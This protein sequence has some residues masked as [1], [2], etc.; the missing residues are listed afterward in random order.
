MFEVGVSSVRIGGA[1]SSDIV[2][3]AGAAEI[4]VYRQRCD[5][6]LAQHAVR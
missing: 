6:C 3:F 2:V 5:L 1:S 4:H